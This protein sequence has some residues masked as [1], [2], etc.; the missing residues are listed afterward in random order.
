MMV[1][2]LKTSLWATQLLSVVEGPVT[3]FLFTHVMCVPFNSY[4]VFLEFDI[5]D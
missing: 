2:L 4:C 3:I 5:Q 1:R